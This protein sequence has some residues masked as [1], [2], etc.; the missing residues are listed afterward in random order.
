MSDLQEV[1]WLE[2][3]K[4]GNTQKGFLTPAEYGAE[5]GERPQLPFTIGRAVWLHGLGPGMVRGQHANRRSQQVFFCLTGSLD[6]L[7]DPGRV[8]QAQVYHLSE[9]HKGLYMAPLVW[10]TL[11]NFE[12]NSVVLILSSEPYDEA[13][14][15]RDYQE[16]KKE[17][18]L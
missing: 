9:P 2:L 17:V 10:R 16:F 3:P 4:I 13:D 15:I 5:Y 7:A 8:S 6:I 1:R 18:G 14:Y 11:Q 12:R